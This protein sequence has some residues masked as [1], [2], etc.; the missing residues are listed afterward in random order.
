[1]QTL[2]S[3][4]LH[5]NQIGAAGA[6]SIGKALETNNVMDTITFI[7]ITIILVFHI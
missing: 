3:L 1:M 2:I 6:Q 7:Y 5:S 4:Y